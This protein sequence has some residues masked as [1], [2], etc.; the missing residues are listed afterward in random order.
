MFKVGS[1]LMGDWF[2]KKCD[3]SIFPLPL[4]QEL[5]NKTM[6]IQDNKPICKKCLFLLEYEE[7][8]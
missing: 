4:K 1:A 5:E 3:F 2:C 8:A 7:Y 6:C